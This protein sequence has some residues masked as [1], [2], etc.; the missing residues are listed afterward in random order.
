MKSRLPVLVCNVQAFGG[1]AVY[2]ESQMCLK[3]M[4]RKIYEDI[5][6]CIL[7]RHETCYDFIDAVNEC[8]VKE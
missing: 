6:I 8:F 7:R 3:I 5:A 1:S 2:Y 4:L